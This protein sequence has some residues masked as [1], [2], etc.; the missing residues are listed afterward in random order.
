MIIESI[1]ITLFVVFIIFM[2]RE[3]NMSEAESTYKIREKNNKFFDKMEKKKR[4]KSL[5]REVK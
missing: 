5:T 2:I 1:A 3:M 4:K